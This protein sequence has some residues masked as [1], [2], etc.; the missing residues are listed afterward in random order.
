MW[1]TFFEANANDPVKREKSVKERKKDP[2]Y[3]GRGWL[4]RNTAPS[5]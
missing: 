4:F 5:L 3:T 2:E 1:G